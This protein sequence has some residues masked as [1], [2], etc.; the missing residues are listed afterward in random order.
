[1]TYKMESLSQRPRACQWVSNILGPQ[2]SS[3]DRPVRLGWH[4]RTAGGSRMVLDSSSLAVELVVDC[5]GGQ[6]VSAVEAAL[7]GRANRS[8]TLGE[9]EDTALGN[10]GC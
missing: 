1:M 4:K 7:D 9:A 8:G 5:P 2:N 10:H 3:V 6:L